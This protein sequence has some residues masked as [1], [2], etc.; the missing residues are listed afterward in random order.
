MDNTPNFMRYF[1]ISAVLF[2]FLLGPL[3]I[4]R[5]SL[6]ESGIIESGLPQYEIKNHENWA[7][8]GRIIG[9]AKNAPDFEVTILTS[10]KEEVANTVS[11]KLKDGKKAY[12]VWLKPGA[13]IL[14]V[15]AAGYETT[16]FHKLEVRA[17]HDLRI[18]LEFTKR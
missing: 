3:F 13:Y 4:P 14:V 2:F 5:Q 18:D 17:G 12:E 11:E 9:I 7:S 16:D 8:K 10:S 15:K 6:A 1:I